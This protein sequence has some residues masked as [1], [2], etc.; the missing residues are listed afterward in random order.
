MVK[1]LDP[2]GIGA[3]LPPPVYFCPCA[4]GQQE[5]GASER[6]EAVASGPP[7]AR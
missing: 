7:V 2:V 5:G 6:S 1:K 3:G 4:V